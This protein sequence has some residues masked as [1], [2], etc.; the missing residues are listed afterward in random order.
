[1][2]LAR[3]ASS[4]SRLN[5]GGSTYDATIAAQSRGNHRARRLCIFLYAAHKEMECRGIDKDSWGIVLQYCAEVPW[6]EELRARRR[7][8]TIPLWRRTI[9]GGIIA[10]SSLRATRLPWYVGET[11]HPV[12]APPR[13]VVVWLGNGL[14]RDRHH[15]SGWENRCMCAACVRQR[16]VPPPAP[17]A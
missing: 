13:E 5:G 8:A 10:E 11:F 7:A 14:A 6:A 1:M 17:P 4:S 16:G 3:K 15:I 2:P 9:S 12:G